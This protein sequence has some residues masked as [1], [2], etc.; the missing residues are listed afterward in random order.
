MGEVARR[1]VVTGSNVTA[2]VDDLERARAGDCGR[3]PEGDRRATVITLTEGGRNA[4]AQMAPD[5]CRLDRGDFRGDA[6]S[7]DKR[8]LI[9]QSRRAQGYDAR[10]AK[11]EPLRVSETAS[12]KRR[13]V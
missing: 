6:E 2:V 8:D 12:I 11:Q 4:F 7:E 13:V 3:P 5:P 1:T 9:Q 10:D